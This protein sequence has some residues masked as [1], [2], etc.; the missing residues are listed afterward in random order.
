M[1]RAARSILLSLVLPLAAFA[2]EPAAP[3]RNPLAFGAGVGRALV[4]G[5]GGRAGWALRLRAVAPVGQHVELG[6]E[7]L[8][9]TSVFES[10][11]T[12][13]VAATFYPGAGLFL[14]GGVGATRWEETGGEVW[15]D[16]GVSRSVGANALAGAGYALGGTRGLAASINV[17]GQLHLLERP[18]G[19]AWRRS[20]LLWLGLDWR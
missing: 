11:S 14:R 5:S 10:L 9:E 1:A 17:E 7:A 6:L 8:A 13:D 19:W 12:L 16:L 20:A 4:E 3:A 15:H 18:G 2:E